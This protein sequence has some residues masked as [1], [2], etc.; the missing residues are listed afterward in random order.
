VS[1]NCFLFSCVCLVE[2]S[3][4]RCCSNNKEILGVRVLGIDSDVVSCVDCFFLLDL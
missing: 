4:E 2:R 3:L 1:V